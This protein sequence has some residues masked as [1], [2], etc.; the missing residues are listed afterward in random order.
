M[1]GQRTVITTSAGLG[2]FAWLILVVGALSGRVPLG[3]LE[4]LFL[5]APLVVVP[6]GFRLRDPGSGLL[7]AAC[8]LQPP[9][10]A[11]AVTSFWIARGAPAAA[12]ACGWAIFAGLAGL[13]AVPELVRRGWRL[14]E[15][16]CGA[17]GFL[18]LTVGAAWLVLSR[19]GTAPLGFGEPIVF[20]TAI[21]F[22]F[23]GFSASV[24]AWVVL[25]KV[26]RVAPLHRALE[27]VVVG[28]VVAGPVL[29]AAGFLTSDTIRLGATLLLAACLCLLAVL[30]W[31]SR[32][33]VENRLSRS[34]LLISSASIVASMLLAAVY[35]WGEVTEQTLLGIPRMVRLHGT[36]NALG[37]A[38][39]GL[40]AWNL[41]E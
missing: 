5:L 20:L 27:I 31:I 39:C 36:L 18:Y 10:A 29:V 28:G 15:E 8:F 3:A 17:A 6:L 37:F 13:S 1:R 16:T 34:L 32:P 33:Q 23:A 19:L 40:L 11:L 24:L 9:A 4:L 41:E 12:L 14:D 30:M 25:R 22:H 38:V 2:G 7:R 35:A 26:R 21:H